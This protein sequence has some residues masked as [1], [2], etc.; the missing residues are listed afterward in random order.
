MKISIRTP[1]YIDPI[2]L[3]KSKH[4]KGGEHYSLGLPLD[5]AKSIY[6]SIY[7]MDDCLDPRHGID[8][9]WSAPSQMSVKVWVQIQVE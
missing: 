1:K 2:V 5:V 7:M 3:G 4:R 9:G 6:E 8:D